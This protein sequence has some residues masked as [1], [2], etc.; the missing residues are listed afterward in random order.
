MPG[1]TFLADDRV[2]LRPIEEDDIGFLCEGDND[3]S[4]RRLAGGDAVPISREDERAALREI[5]ARAGVAL[6]VTAEGDEEP[7]RLGYIELDPIDQV[8]GVA[9]LGF[10]IVAEHR[11]RGFASASIDLVAA[12]AFDELRLHRLEAEVYDGNEAS[13]AFLHEKGFVEE[14]TRREAA[15]V[16][17]AHVDVR[18]FG[19]LAPE[20]RG[21]R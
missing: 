1:P 17:G 16:D 19:L 8:A 14:G 13:V 21:T 18:G 3:P 4:I 5:E 10:W 2:A 15:F 9:E 6:L 20:W 7:V 11:R 12:Y